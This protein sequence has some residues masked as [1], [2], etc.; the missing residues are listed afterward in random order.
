M[1]NVAQ[2]VIKDAYALFCLGHS[3]DDGCAELDESTVGLAPN[4]MAAGA[5][6][7]PGGH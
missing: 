6:A 5:G 7:L 4:A 3:S 2:P 1:R